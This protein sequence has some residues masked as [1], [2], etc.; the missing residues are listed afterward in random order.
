MREVGGDWDVIVHGFILSCVWMVHIGCMHGGVLREGARAHARLTDN[1][2]LL[3]K[4]QLRDGRPT[5]H[6]GRPR[7]GNY[8]ELNKKNDLLSEVETREVT[9]E[10]TIG[11]HHVLIVAELDTPIDGNMNKTKEIK[12]KLNEN[13]E[14]FER[15]HICNYNDKLQ[16]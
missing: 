14:K 12:G 9:H 15:K 6:N 2:I 13:M 7:E 10:K 11:F 1:I 5:Q 16:T 8:V 4:G 3:R